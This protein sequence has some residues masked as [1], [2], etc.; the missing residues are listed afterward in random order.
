MKVVGIIAE[1]NPFHKGHAYQL[2]TIKKETHADYVIIAMSGNFVQRGA[3]ALME[4]YSRAEMALGCGAD[5]VLELPVLFATASAEMFAAGGVGLLERTGVVTQLCFGT[6]SENF[7]LLKQT[8]SFLINPTTLFSETLQQELKKG[9]SFPA[10]RAKAL[11]FYMQNAKNPSNVDMQELHELLASPNN[12]LAIEYLKALQSCHSNIQPCPIL[13]KGAGYHDISLEHD[14]CSASAIRS[15]L[16][17]N[18]VSTNQKQH[19]SSDSSLQNTA[20]IHQEYLKNAMP[21]K[22]YEILENYPHPF[23][24]EDDFSPLVHYKL[25]TESPEILA[26]YLDSSEELANRMYRERYQFTSYSQFCEHL[27]TR[28]VTYTRMSRLL[29]HMLLNIREADCQ[30]SD[31]ALSWLKVLGFRKSAAPLLKKIRESSPVSLIVH[32]SDA[33]RLLADTPSALQAFEKQ[34]AASDLYQLGLTAKGGVLPLKNDYRHPV[35]TWQP[36]LP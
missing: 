34:V 3:P 6:E 13:R 16:K 17:K 35:V 36:S 15:H 20:S 9:C 2:E 32:A 14:F 25:F 30:Y 28:N 10:A 8:A 26:G 4:K 7:E 12:I 19:V 29:L 21:K 22:A 18:N 23:L 1:Y 27:K 5:L 11:S 33:S 24:Y 31:A